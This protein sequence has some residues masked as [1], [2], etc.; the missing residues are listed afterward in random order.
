MSDTAPDTGTEDT[1]TT[2]ETA[3]DTDTAPD[4][5]AEV[6][7][8]KKQARKHE[9]RAKANA[10]AAQEL[11]TLRQQSMTEQERAVDEA[12]TEARASALAEVGGRVAAA[13]IRAAAAGRMAPEQ[14][15]VLLDGLNVTRFLD[16]SGEV[17]RDKVAAFV[18]GIAP[19]TTDDQSFPDLGQGTRSTQQQMALNGDPLQRTLER[20]LGIR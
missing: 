8:W 3:P 12:R 4:L 2:T 9:E 19:K 15:D 20:K 16:E 5:A 7:K 18:D 10:T 17:D 11:D 1:T 6:E 13:E 14:L